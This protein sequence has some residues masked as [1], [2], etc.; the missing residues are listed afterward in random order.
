MA[1][2]AWPDAGPHTVTVE[3]LGDPSSRPT[4]AVDAAFVLE[5]AP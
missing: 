5:P 3:V 4:V 2:A 1:A